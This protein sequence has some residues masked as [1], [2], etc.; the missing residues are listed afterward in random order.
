VKF[1][2][3]PGA[4]VTNLDSGSYTG[5]LVK[6]AGDATPVYATYLGSSYTYAGAILVDANQE[7]TLAGTG[8][9]P[10]SPPP[11]TAPGPA[12]LMKLN[13][14]GSQVVSVIP[15]QGTNSDG[16]TSAISADSE[17]NLLIAG[18]TE[19]L[20]TTSGAYRSPPVVSLCTAPNNYSFPGADV[21]LMK[22]A[23]ADWQP[24]FTA[25]LSAPCG[26]QFGGM[27]VDREGNVV[28]GLATGNGLPLHNP[29][30]AGPVCGLNSS[31]VAKINADG[32]ALRFS[33]YLDNC[34]IP[35]IALAPDGS[36]YAGVSSSGN[37]N[38]SGVLKLNPAITP[39]ISLDG[40]ANAFSGDG[41]S[42]VA[43]GLY[44]L[45]GSG[46]GA[47]SIDFGLNPS[48][49]LPFEI[50]GVQVFFNGVPAALLQTSPVA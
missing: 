14:A 6:F 46:F 50:S 48:R 13:A 39:P 27:A 5:F 45:T 44:S 4:L 3:T 9:V 28:L 29:L 49:N 35:A 37:E 34:Q 23:A 12:F 31:A 42:V 38:A 22:L 18:E 25:S 41:T 2:V 15:L 47:P 40:I 21:Y 10:G 7:A 17:G 20:M 8:T 33:T 24:M 11:V 19:P 1:P 16:L 32:S 26:I 36:I 43:G 30:L